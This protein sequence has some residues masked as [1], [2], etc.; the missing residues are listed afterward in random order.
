VIETNLTGLPLEKLD[1]PALLIDLDQF[2]QNLARMQHL[3][4][5]SH[6]RCRPHV[7]SHKS[8]I[9]AHLQVRHGAVGVCCAKVG[10]AEAMVA[11]G[12]SD[13][14]V[15][16]PV[17]SPEKISRLV[18]LARRA[19]V[20]VVADH[21]DNVNAL[22]E[23]ASMSK[24]SLKVLIEI[25]V[26]QQRCGLPPGAAAADLADRIANSRGL[27]FAGLQ[28]YQGRLQAIVSFADRRREVERSLALLL[29]TAEAVRNRGHPVEVLTGGGTGS[30]G[31]DIELGGLNELQPGSYVF[32]DSTYRRIEWEPGQ[33]SPFEPSLSIL[34]SVV[35]RP[36]A[37]RLVLDVGWKT[38]SSDSGPPVAKTTGWSFEFAGDEHGIL[39]RTGGLSL[40]LGDKIELVPSHCDT[41]VNLY[42]WFFGIRNGRIETV[43]PIAARGRS[44]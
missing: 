32:M 15:T 10:E 41:T 39:H 27:I 1:T 19:D 31:I 38:A 43:W 5:G 36:S 17:S 33:A 35:S 9:I 2:E 44:Q 14:H 21:F 22:A 29:E 3:I 8:P 11:G 6:C 25:D 28:G 42:D 18:A 12:I 4:A 7:K 23:A 37:E 16:T 40:A 30:S 34:G 26:G 20:S 24:I 13:V